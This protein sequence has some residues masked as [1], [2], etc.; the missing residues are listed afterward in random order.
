M[1]WRWPQPDFGAG[2][3]SNATA[4]VPSR[5]ELALPSL[6][7]AATA[8]LSSV[9]CDEDTLLGASG[10]AVCLARPHR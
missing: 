5:E 3:G 8:A 1:V 10:L 6:L 4:D 7:E 2:D 9:L